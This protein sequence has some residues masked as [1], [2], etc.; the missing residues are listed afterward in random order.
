MSA[1]IPCQ[2]IADYYH[3]KWESQK[4]ILYNLLRQGYR[5]CALGN[6]TSTVCAIP[7]NNLYEKSRMQESNQC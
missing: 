7:A 5:E 3:S 1:P 6:I 2:H 4:C